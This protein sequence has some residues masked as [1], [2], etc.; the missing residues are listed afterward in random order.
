METI[1]TIFWL[2]NFWLERPK[3]PPLE[4]ATPV[5]LNLDKLP[6]LAE[7]P[8]Q[9]LVNEF[10]PNY[11]V[12]IQQL[13][14]QLSQIQTEKNKLTHEKET[15]QNYLADLSEQNTILHQKR[16]Q[17]A[18]E[19]KQ[20]IN[21]LEQKLTGEQEKRLTAENNLAQEKQISHNLRQQ[22]Q[23]EKQNNQ[24]LRETNTNLTQKLSQQEQNHTNLINTYQIALK[25]KENTQKQLNNL[26]ATIKA[27]AKQFHQWQKINYYQ[28]L[29]K[30][31]GKFQAQMIQ[32][33]P[34][35]MK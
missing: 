8:P 25:D 32:P 27:T 19:T 4:S 22:L 30:E 9:P 2:V 28:Q 20:I 14:Q 11:L 24:I 1:L 34:W 5:N 15:L 6:E 17:I 3:N 33:P 29:E 10:R 16:N 18:T 21:Q 7:I 26:L 31:Q 23:A 35:K 12:K 13:E